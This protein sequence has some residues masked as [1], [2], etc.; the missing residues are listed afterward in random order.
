[1][2]KDRVYCAYLNGLLGSKGYYERVEEK[3]AYVLGVGESPQPR[4]KGA[5]LADVALLLEEAPPAPSAPPVEGE[6]A[7]VCIPTEAIKAGRPLRLEDADG[8]HPNDP[9][10]GPF[11][12]LTEA[13]A[14][15]WIDSSHQSDDMTPVP[16]RVS[17]LTEAG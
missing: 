17:F 5:V 6:V 7:W 15:A 8:D 4:P 2:D 9:D 12:F 10:G 14:R 1:M 13:V 3:T 11:L 16:V